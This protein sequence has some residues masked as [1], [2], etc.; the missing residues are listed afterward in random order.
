MYSLF[1]QLAE[2]AGDERTLHTTGQHL[3]ATLVR[4]HR[5][6]LSARQMQGFF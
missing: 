4:Q 1:R 3:L 5:R 2:P 6:Q